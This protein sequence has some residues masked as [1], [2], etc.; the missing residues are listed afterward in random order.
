MY[1][2]FARIRAR[3]P[4]ILFEFMR[5]NVQSELTSPSGECEL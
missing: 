1:Y 3:Q 2:A 5:V 4:P